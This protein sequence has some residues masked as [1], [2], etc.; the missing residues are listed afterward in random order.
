MQTVSNYIENKTFLLK[1]PVRALDSDKSNNIKEKYSLVQSKNGYESN[2]FSINQEHG[3]ITLVNRL[4]YEVI[5]TI[6]KI[7]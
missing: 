6:K 4:D 5:K 3:W 7:Q 1:F 2:L